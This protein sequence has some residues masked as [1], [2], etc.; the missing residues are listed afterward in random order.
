MNPPH[1][2]LVLSGVSNWASPN[3]DIIGVKFD[4]RF[5]FEDHVRGIQL[6]ATERVKRVIVT[7]L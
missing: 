7:Q 5:T 6:E 1:G 3:L 4:T 2:D